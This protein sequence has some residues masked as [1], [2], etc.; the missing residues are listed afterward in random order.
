MTSQ[1]LHP[2]PSPLHRLSACWSEARPVVQ[3]IFQLRFWAAVALTAPQ[4]FTARPASVLLG[5][6][7]WLCATWYVYL[8]NG[9]SDQVED[10]ANGST[11]P[12]AS[13]SLPVRAAQR[14]A[15]SLAVTA[16]LLALAVS[17]RL[18]VLT[19]IMLVLGWVYSAGPSPQK[20]SL[21]G[22]AVV[23]TMG[24]VVTYLAGCA[25]AGGAVS[26]ELLVL[27]LSMSLWMALAGCT[28]DLGDAA[29]DRAAGRRTLPVLLGDVRARRLTAVSVLLA[30]A[31]TVTATALAAP[32]LLLP[33]FLL[34]VGALCVAILTVAGAGAWER[35]RQRRPYRYFMGSQYAVHLS[36]VV[37]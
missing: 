21:L 37:L 20:R 9:V 18:A 2:A 8:I 1:V 19:A 34:G 7:A 3:I 16:L 28:K 5:G 29:G 32:G 30:G 33:A 25:A 15:T 4:A 24:G 10:R 14:V 6:A 36:I 23:V 22:F 12:L 31:G 35:S 17:P 27:M 13:G 11:R 26:P